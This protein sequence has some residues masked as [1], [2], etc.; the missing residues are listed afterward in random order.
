MG[1]GDEVAVCDIG[2]LLK[3]ARVPWHL[4]GRFLSGEK[5]AVDFGFASNVATCL[6]KE[7]LKPLKDS[8]LIDLFVL[9]QF[10][11]TRLEPFF[12][13]FSEVLRD[14][15]GNF[16][17]L[18]AKSLNLESTLAQMMKDD[19]GWFILIP[20]KLAQF[21][22]QN[23][24][25]KDESRFHPGEHG[26]GSQRR[27]GRRCDSRPGRLWTGRCHD[28]GDVERR[29]TWERVADPNALDRW[30][31]LSWS[32]FLSVFREHVGSKKRAISSAL[33]W[34]PM[35]VVYFYSHIPWIT[36]ESFGKSEVP[37][38]PKTNLHDQRTLGQF[39]WIYPHWG[40][41]HMSAV[42]SGLDRSSEVCVAAVTGCQHA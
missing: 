33:V 42:A 20:S 35:L 16:G 40:A 6:N 34:W 30:Q 24:W 2:T 15:I 27:G 29:S 22:P 13:G 39:S 7:I 12:W 17:I 14:G 18:W 38:G 26:Q 9:L 32:K 41:K 4:C 31:I 36:R 25:A 28:F 5:T 23:F 21:W 11:I 1:I 3:L 19:Q 10:I 37:R 8:T